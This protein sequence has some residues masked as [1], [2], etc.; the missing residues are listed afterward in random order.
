MEYTDRKRIIKDINGTDY[1]QRYYM[2]LKNR[3]TFPF[4]I[5]IHKFLNSDDD[6]MHNHPWSYFTIILKGGYWEETFVD[7]D[8][9]HSEGKMKKWCGPGY[10]QYSNA[11]H[12]HRITLKQNVDCWTLFIPF[13]QKQNWGFWKFN[14]KPNPFQNPHKKKKK[15]D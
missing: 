9:T 10:F 4:N 2:F 11:D 12:I 3:D 7:N 14:G 1:L 8:P 6:D 5:F 13:S 15:K